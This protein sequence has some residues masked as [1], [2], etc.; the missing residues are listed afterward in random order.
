VN[1]GVQ[2]AL[3][4]I[5]AKHPTQ[6]EARSPVAD[7]Q[8]AP[9]PSTRQ[10]TQRRSAKLEPASWP[11]PGPID[12]VMQRERAFRAWFNQALAE[13][14]RVPG[15]KRMATAEREWLARQAMLYLYETRLERAVETFAA[16][17]LALPKEEFLRGGLEA[18]EHGSVPFA[19]SFFRAIGDVERL[20]ALEP[21]RGL[22]R[23]EML[24]RRPPLLGGAPP[25][26]ESEWR[27]TVDRIFGSAE[28]RETPPP[29]RM[30]VARTPSTANEISVAQLAELDPE[31][32][33]DGDW[34]NPIL[35]T[36]TISGRPMTHKQIMGE[37]LAD[38]SQSHPGGTRADRRH[39]EE[40]IDTTLTKMVERGVLVERGSTL[41][42]NI[43]LR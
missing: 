35:V 33:P 5:V 15:E 43:D 4:A 28:T 24:R 18:L 39:E 3:D 17:G 12:Q 20:A 16:A 26:P 40:R 2:N 9:A 42:L 29:P 6:Q 7:S 19:E 22:S 38:F 41:E 21:L 13:R 37:L 32:G 14:E 31:G 27:A 23:Q 25:E 34:A 11:P 10:S 36:L 1:P 30:R 8:A